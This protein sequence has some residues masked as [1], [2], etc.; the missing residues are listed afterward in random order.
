MRLSLGEVVRAT[1]GEL[2]GEPLDAETIFENVST[3]TRTLKEGSLFVALKG[4][5]FDAHDYLGEAVDKGAGALVVSRGPLPRGCT[6]VVVA[7]TLDALGELG[8]AAG[9]KGGFKVAAITGSFGKTTTKQMCASIIEAAGE[10]VLYTPGNLNNR[11]GLPLTLLGAKGDEKFAVL[12]LGISEPGEMQKLSNIAQPQVALITGAGV[13]HTEL[14]GSVEGVA[15]E[16]MEISHGM[17]PGSILLLP[18][19]DENLSPAM[20]RRGIEV[21]TFGWD[22][23]SAVR[24]EGYR[25]TAAGSVFTVAGREIEVPLPGRHNADNALAAWALV[26]ALGVEIDSGARIVASV[27]QLAMRS[28]IRTGVKGAKFYVDCYNANPSAMAAAMETVAGLAD[29]KRMIG[30]LGE[31]L[32]LGSMSKQAHL[33]VGRAA[34]RSGFKKLYLVG[35]G[36]LIGEETRWI[37][38]GAVEAGMAPEA[39][40]IFEDVSPIIEGLAGEL[41]GDDWVLIKGSR[42]TGLDRVA[43]AMAGRD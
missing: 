28:E 5:R 27:G 21:R 29:G 8:R 23:G 42:A 17:E 40:K 31:M 41:A 14:L 13:A 11:I 20:V 1:S 32:E 7:D 3:D 9:E 26:T 38:Q 25:T 34:A 35:V 33:E 36:G 2:R 16:K 30:V 12:E 39:V 22:E 19:G 10:K 43:D 6:A 4:E 37:R 18:H 15:E 24:G